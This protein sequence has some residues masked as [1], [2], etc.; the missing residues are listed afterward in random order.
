MQ[1]YADIKNLKYPKSK[2]KLSPEVNKVE[3]QEITTAHV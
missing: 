2:L 3:M 1:K